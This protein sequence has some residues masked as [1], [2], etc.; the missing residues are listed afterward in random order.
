[1]KKALIL[2]STGLGLAFSSPLVY[3]E[4]SSS[5]VPSM[6]ER[7]F[8]LGYKIGYEY[9]LV[10]EGFLKKTVQQL[11]ELNVL[12][13]LLKR[14]QNKCVEI[15]ECSKNCYEITIRIP[16]NAPSLIRLAKH[17]KELQKGKRILRGW[18]VYLDGTNIPEVELGW[19]IEKAQKLGYNPIKIGKVI[20][21]DTEPTKT[22]AEYVK[23]K[24]IK[25]GIK[26]VEVSYVE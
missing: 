12:I 11:E 3:F 15:K 2:L 25:A 9:C 22:D 6:W 14:K 17:I 16:K 7:G 26:G 21:F 1:M 10:D 23:N 19:Y 13:N 4:P 18:I 24:L 20:I 5:T 8:E